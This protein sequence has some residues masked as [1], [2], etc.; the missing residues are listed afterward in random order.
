[1]YLVI[2][3]PGCKTFTYVDRFQRWKLCPVC[4]EA[5]DVRR[6]P[7]YLEVD[8]YFIAEKIVGELEKYLHRRR[9]KD[10]TQEEIDD[11][12]RQYADWLRTQV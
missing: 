12:R 1:M 7:A 9:R 5:T 2:R 4:G 8:D 11:L 6:A 10:L 3:C